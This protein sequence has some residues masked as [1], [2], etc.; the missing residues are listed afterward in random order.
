MFVIFLPSQI[1]LEGGGHDVERVGAA[2]AVAVEA[3]LA[4]QKEVAHPQLLD[5]E[6]LLLGNLCVLL[7]VADVKLIRN[8]GVALF[9]CHPTSFQILVYCLLSGSQRHPADTSIVGANALQIQGEGAV[10]ERSIEHRPPISYKPAVLNATQK[11]V[12]V[13]HRQHTPVATMCRRRAKDRAEP[14]R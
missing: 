5:H 8:G 13:A 3:N 10:P 6:W 1:F 12:N 11:I 14:I 2:G 7:D 4:V 9:N